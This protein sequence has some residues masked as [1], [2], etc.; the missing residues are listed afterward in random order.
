MKK[1]NILK[2]LM[3]TLLKLSYAP[4]SSVLNLQSNYRLELYDISSVH[5]G[6]T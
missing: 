5:A 2:M 6:S 1:L 4:C 3:Y